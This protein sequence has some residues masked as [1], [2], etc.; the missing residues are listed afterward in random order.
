MNWRADHNSLTSNILLDSRMAPCYLRLP[1]HNRG[2]GDRSNRF[3]ISTF[4]HVTHCL[5]QKEGMMIRRTFGILMCLALAVFVSLATAGGPPYGPAAGPCGRGYAPNPCAYWGD[6]PFPGL[7][8]GVVGL[9]FLVVGSLLGGNPT[10]PCGPPPSPR[11]GCAPPPYP[12]A[13]VYAPY[14]GPGGYQGNPLNQGLFG[15]VPGFNV[16]TDLIGS[17]TGGEGLL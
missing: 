1:G 12:P 5:K 16:A 13:R 8:G 14:P 6:A 11:Y 15:A 9:P 17:V 3:P 4:R 7:C 10:G 2:R